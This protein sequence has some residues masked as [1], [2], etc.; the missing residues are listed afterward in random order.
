[1]SIPQ[2]SLGGA[3]L[4]YVHIQKYL[5]FIMNEHLLDNDDIKR[6]L[7]CTYTRGNM[8]ISKFRHCSNDVKAKLF[9]AYCTNFYGINLW[10]NFSNDTMR[11]LVVAYKRIFRN[12]MHIDQQKTTQQM[13]EVNVDPFDVIER[14]Y[15]FGFRERLF[16]CTNAIVCNIIQ[17][18]FFYVTSLYTGWIKKLFSM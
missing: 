12:T 9:K 18:D 3:S 4:K 16:N 13:L 1:M 15:I 5:G 11:K 7:R 6:Q 10:S 2:F 8:I 14:N 17:N